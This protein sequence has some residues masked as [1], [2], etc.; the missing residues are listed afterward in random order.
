MQKQELIKAC[1]DYF[2][3]KI[4]TLNLI[5]S[6]LTESANSESKSSAG[7]KHETS[8][9]M[10]QLER[11]KLG[12]QLKEGEEQLAEFEKINFN[13]NFQMIE[14]GC[15]IETDKGYFFIAGSVGKMKVGDEFIFVISWKSPLARALEGKKNKDVVNFNGTA[16]EII[17]II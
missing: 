10:M 3:N 7:D 9:A 1:D 2:K 11:E 8:K 17:S 13:K 16:Y 15:L 14:Q 5:I 12:N 4:N 6:E